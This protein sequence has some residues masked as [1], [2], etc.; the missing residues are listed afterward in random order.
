[1]HA[2]EPP[3]HSELIHYRRRPYWHFWFKR[4]TARTAGDVYSAMSCPESILWHS[5]L[6]RRVIVYVDSYVPEEHGVSIFK[7]DPDDGGSMISETLIPTDGQDYT[8]SQRRA[9]QWT[10]IAV[11]SSLEWAFAF[12]VVFCCFAWSLVLLQF[13]TAFTR[14]SVTQPNHRSLIAVLDCDPRVQQ[15]RVRY[16]CCTQP[17]DMPR[18]SHYR[19]FIMTAISGSLKGLYNW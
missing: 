8:E 2:T 12:F 13:L 19:T 1:M 3:T 18:P 7:I 17:C 9:S 10:L 15:T 5:G 11:I 4:L 14:S 6:W 16:S